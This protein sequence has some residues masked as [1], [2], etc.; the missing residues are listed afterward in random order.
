MLRKAL[1]IEMKSRQSSL[2]TKGELLRLFSFACIGVVNTA[3]DAAV[4]Y[5]L[6]VTIELHVVPSNIISFSCA[7]IFSYIMNSRFTFNEEQ[8][9]T[10]YSANQLI[11]FVVVTICGMIIATIAVWGL[12]QMMGL[13]TAKLISIGITFFWNYLGYKVLVFR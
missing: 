5:S 2:L 11:R 10:D 6:A 13:M 3:I 1:R 7:V 4:F 9:P 12:S 8:K